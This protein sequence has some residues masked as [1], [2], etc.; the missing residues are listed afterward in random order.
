MDDVATSAADTYRGARARSREARRAR[1]LSRVPTE[2]R[3]DRGGAEDPLARPHRERPSA[4]PLWL[5]TSIGAHLAMGVLGAI[6]PAS[7]ARAPRAFEQSVE[8]VESP[9]P[10]PPPETAP[11]VPPPDRPIEPT[12]PVVTRSK[13][14][15]QA[16]VPAPT[17]T[18]EPPPDPTEPAAASPEPTSTRPARRVI[19]LNLG[20]T[21]A[22]ASGPSFAVGSTRMG[23]TSRIAADPGS[24]GAQA[25]AQFVPPRRTREESP[26]YPP[27]LRA[28]NVEGD[29]VLK[30][31]VD[32]TGHVSA[33]TV[34]APSPHDAFNQAA[35]A[36]AKR[37]VYA[38]ALM[39]GAAV[40]NTI[41][42]TVR[43]RL[44]Q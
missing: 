10:P 24:G 21:V 19:G 27:T 34:V 4:V 23:E 40:A 32:A 37:S 13:P 1:A 39:N 5:A 42:F 3:L 7:A 33:V 16:E 17:P 28:R 9:K 20:S 2:L 25:G 29:V 26:E 18:N 36:S 31:D 14:V 15:V 44:K 12:E 30:V 38:P 22:G 41:Q 35:I 6:A 11:A 8:I 43:F